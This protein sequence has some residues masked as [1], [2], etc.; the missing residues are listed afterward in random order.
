MASVWNVTY[1]DLLAAAGQEW[2]QTGSVVQQQLNIL[3]RA[4]ID[5]LNKGARDPCKT[6][7]SPK[8]HGGYYV[9]KMAEAGEQLV[10]QGAMH[11]A[12]SRPERSKQLGVAVLYGRMAHACGP[13]C[14]YAAAWAAAC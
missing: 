2:P 11:A 14:C 5:G 4:M 1:G 9:L 8:K 3:A 12:D 7:V 10:N 13:L 6:S